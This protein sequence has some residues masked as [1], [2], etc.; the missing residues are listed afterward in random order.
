MQDLNDGKVPLQEI[1]IFFTKTKKTPPPPPALIDDQN[2]I[3]DL[4]ILIRSFWLFFSLG[5]F[6]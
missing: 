4:I 5:F 3:L 1:P 6:Y 2:V